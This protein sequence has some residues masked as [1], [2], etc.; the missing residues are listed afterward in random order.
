MKL[1]ERI[2]RDRAELAELDRNGRLLFLWDYYKIPIISI[3]CAVLLTAVTIL[4]SAGSGKAAM[5]AV[6]V[7]AFN[8]DGDRA[9]LDSLLEESGVELKGRHIDVTANLTLGQELDELG[10]A[11][12]MQVL[13]ALFGISGL[14]FFAANDAAFDR[15]ASQGAF[16]DLGLFLDRE[17]L[18][19]LGDDCC[20][21]VSDDGTSTL[22][23]IRLHD[24][25]PLHKAGYYVSDVLAGIAA[26]AE[27]L[28]EAVS[29][30]KALL[31]A[32]STP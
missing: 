5:Y 21:T 9:A 2:R 29:F 27:H 22:T 20:Y 15:Y 7:N 16:L 26:N 13:A 4:T 1:T 32:E 23:A 12:S 31:P 14:D 30:L 17:T 8:A 6:F 11:Q 19:R 18:N 10:D 25:S 28:D 24:G 3:L